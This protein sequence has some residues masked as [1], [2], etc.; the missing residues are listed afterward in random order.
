MKHTGNMNRNF[1]QIPMTT[2][3]AAIVAYFASEWLHM[4]SG[5]RM[6]LL[7][8][9][10]IGRWFVPNWITVRSFMAQRES[11]TSVCWIRSRIR[12]STSAWV[13][14]E[15][16][17]PQA[18][19]WKQTRCPWNF[20]E[21]GLRHNI[22]SRYAQIWVTQL[23]TALLTSGSRNS[24]T[25]VRI[26]SALSVSASIFTAELVALNLALDIIR[27]SHRKKFVI[28][29]D[30]L[31]GLLAI[32]NCQLETVY[33]QKFIINYCQLINAGN[34]ITLIWI[35]GHTGIQGNERAD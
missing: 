2:V 3:F 5:V 24:L 13:H 19:M 6:R 18:C 10:C 21:D 28:F 31:S 35:P 23:E 12:H 26:K 1:M 7:Y 14:F 9:I 4:P 20:E 32:H 29:S 16:C 17:Q 11:H 22:C 27:R 30:S 25:N 8:F 33:V 34:R 15:H